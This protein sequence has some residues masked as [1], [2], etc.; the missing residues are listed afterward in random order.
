MLTIASRTTIRWLL[1]GLRDR[2]YNLR[3]MLVIG[4]GQEARHFADRVERH[5]ELGLRVIGFLAVGDAPTDRRPPPGAR[6]LDD[7][8]DIL[9][10]RIV[11]EVAVCLGADDLHRIERD[12]PPVRGGGQDRPHPDRRLSRS[13]CRA[14][15]SRSSTAARSCRSSTARTATS[16][17][18]I[19]RLLDIVA[20][21]LALLVL[22]AGLRHPG[23]RD[24]RRSTDGPVLFRQTRV[25]LHGRPFK[26]VKFRTMVPDAEERLAELEDR[27]EIKGHAFKV[28]QRPAGHPRRRASCARP[29]ST[30]CPSCGTCCAAR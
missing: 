11:D 10:D 18:V 14:A 7:I 13:A 30:S 26:V 19:K 29:A 9:H 8:E 1:R 4:T 23:D 27:N 24:A 3:Y 12:R 22:L 6:H 16:A 28:D 5:R 2:G 15:A 21:G 20:V 17:L 25:G